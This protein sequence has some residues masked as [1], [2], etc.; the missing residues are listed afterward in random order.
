[1][2]YDLVGSM[3]FRGVRSRAKRAF[4]RRTVSRKVSVSEGY[5][6]VGSA[7]RHGVRSY[8]KG[9]SAWSAAVRGTLFW[10]NAP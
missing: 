10:G 4:P 8:A 6:L 5:G 9:A 3:R 7:Q 1:M 2:G